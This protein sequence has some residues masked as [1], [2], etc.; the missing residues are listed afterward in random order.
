MEEDY[1]ESGS[2]LLSVAY[3]AAISVTVVVLLVLV[4]GCKTQ[5]VPVES[6]HEYVH[7]QTDS[8]FVTDSVLR[9][10]ETIVREV[11]AGDSVLLAKLGLKVDEQRKMLL[12]L[13]RE[14][15]REKSR[16][17]EVCMDTVLKVEER[18]VPYPVERK[19]SAWEQVKVGAVG[20]VCAA[21]VGGL[22]WMVAWIRRRYKRI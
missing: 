3:A 13:Q 10:S 6:V 1:D 11:N 9:E 12:V 4:T 7:H 17:S 5:Y 20:A 19:L 2:W 16:E 21:G 15:E 14:L 8:F 22:I 18:Q